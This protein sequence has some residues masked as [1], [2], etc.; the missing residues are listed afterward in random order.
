MQ[1]SF[2]KFKVISCRCL[3]KGES[4]QEVLA[5]LNLEMGIDDRQVDC[6]PITPD[7]CLAPDYYP[8]PCEQITQSFKILSSF[9]FLFRQLSCL[10]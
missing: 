8:V 9:R 2:A 3:E 10:C 1:Q 5:E 7:V 4:L 6:S